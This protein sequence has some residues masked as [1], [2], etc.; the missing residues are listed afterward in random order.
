MPILSTTGVALMTVTKSPLLLLQQEI[1]DFSLLSSK[2]QEKFAA[3]EFSKNWNETLNELDSKIESAEQE[4]AQLDWRRRYGSNAETNLKFEIG[5]LQLQREE[6]LRQGRRNFQSFAEMSPCRLAIVAKK[7]EALHEQITQL[8][9]FFPLLRLKGLTENLHQEL[10]EPGNVDLVL[11]HFFSLSL[12]ELAANPLPSLEEMVQAPLAKLL[13]E[14][15]QQVSLEGL[16]LDDF[17]EEQAQKMAMSLLNSF[18]QQTEVE[19]E[20]WFKQY[21]QDLYAHLRTQLKPKTKGIAPQD[22]QPGVMDSLAFFWENGAVERAQEFIDKV[23]EAHGFIQAIGFATQNEN[24]FLAILDTYNYHKHYEKIAQ[25]RKVITNLLS[26]LDPLWDEYRRLASYE[27]D[28]YEQ[29]LGIIMP[30]LVLALPIVGTAILLS[31]WALP[32]LAFMFACI[33]AFL[34]GLS[35]ATCYVSTKNAVYRYVSGWD[36]RHAFDIPQF[37]V[38]SRM[39]AT[40]GKELAEE[41]R[42]FYIEQLKRC[43]SMEKEYRQEQGTLNTNNKEFKK[44]NQQD[45][46]QLYL[47]WYEIHSQNEDQLGINKIPQIVLNRLQKAS[48]KAGQ[49]L[50]EHIELELSEQ[51]SVSRQIREMIGC[52]QETL[53]ED[54]K[55]VVAQAKEEQAPQQAQNLVKQ[56]FFGE[57]S[58]FSRLA[59]NKTKLEEWSRLGEKMD[60]LSEKLAKSQPVPLFV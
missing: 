50:Q 38:N 56:G 44:Q 31:P 51:G 21:Q 45:R 28:V 5:R 12:Q 36:E 23:A 18:Q 25:N 46:Y 39:E 43:D 37:Q 15:M 8:A 34:T 33:P 59:K 17:N 13:A 32:E 29:C 19:Y 42:L 53:L 40:F 3:C 26:L 16:E 24:S 22:Q 4:L 54:N 9:D 11:S 52:V 41:V 48:D 47:E 2:D 27:K 35:L 10:E 57:N 60:G 30:T 14:Y 1:E 20:A 7:K 49:A 58:I 6:V 55:P